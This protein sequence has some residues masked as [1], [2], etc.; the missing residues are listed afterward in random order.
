MIVVGDIALA[1]PSTATEPTTGIGM[2]GGVTGTVPY[3]PVGDITL[4]V[5]HS[6]YREIT[7]LRATAWKGVP[8][9]GCIACHVQVHLPEIAQT[10]GV[11]RCLAGVGQSRQQDGNEQTGDADHHQQFN[12][13]KSG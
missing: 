7:C 10:Y 9:V 13:R 5:Q 6:V 3:L 4:L 8:P 12:E 2:S 1:T 11:L